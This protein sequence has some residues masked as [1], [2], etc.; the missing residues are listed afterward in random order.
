MA[1]SLPYNLADGQTADAAQVMAD[2]NALK[3]A[4]ET[5]ES[6]LSTGIA[7]I[8]GGSYGAFAA[9][10]VNVNQEPSN[11][12]QAEVLILVVG[13]S[14]GGGA[15]I[16]LPGGDTLTGLVPGTYGFSCPAAGTWKWNQFGGSPASEVQAAYRLH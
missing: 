8:L 16:T 12:K 15:T 2:L 7:S 1:I 4:I 13:G 14:G 5:L 9:K 6:G 3:N 11:V 10:T